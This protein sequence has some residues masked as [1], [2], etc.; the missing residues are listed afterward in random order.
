MAYVFTN[1][2]SALLDQQLD[3]GSSTAVLEAGTGSAFPAPTGGDFFVVTL[4]DTDA[5]LE[6]CLCT[7]RSGDTLTLS[8]NQEGSSEQTWPAGTRLEL[9]ATAAT[10]AEFIQ[11]SGDTMSGD[12]DLGSNSLLN[13]LIS[14]GRTLGTLL[15]A[16]DDSATNQIEVPT[17]G[18]RPTIGGAD[19]ALVSELSTYLSPSDNTTITGDWDFTNVLQFNGVDVAVVTDIPSKNATNSLP[20][21]SESTT[22]ASARTITTSDLYNKIRFAPAGATGDATFTFDTGL[23][24]A[25]DMVF[26]ST[27]TDGT[28]TIAPGGATFLHKDGGTG[29]VI[30]TGTQRVVGFHKVTATEWE[31]TGDYD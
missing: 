5:N 11:R 19:I 25:G 9:R 21:I 31:V 6:Y 23:G 13:A 27:D 12:L 15:R 8:R 10:L 3:T 28:L 7:A 4:Q 20:V 18:A 1:N 14:G 29:N 24:S 17:G 22:G 16:T 2:A 26:F 30:I